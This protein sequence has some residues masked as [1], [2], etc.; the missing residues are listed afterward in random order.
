[1]NIGVDFAPIWQGAEDFLEGRSPYAEHTVHGGYIHPPGSTVLISPLSLLPYDVAARLYTMLCACSI[2]A[3]GFLVFR[4][5]PEASWRRIAIAALIV[6]IA[7]PV[8]VALG[9]GNLEPMALLA[10]AA[11]LWALAQNRAVLAGV[12]LGLGLAIKPTLAPL[13]LLPFVVGQV[14]AGGIA[15]ATALAINLFGFLVVPDSDRFFTSAVPFIY[16]VQPTVDLNAALAGIADRYDLGGTAITAFQIIGLVALAGVVI[17]YWRDL[18]NSRY[19]VFAFTALFVLAGLLVPRYSFVP[20]G[21][22]LVL[23]LPLLV[24][25]QTRL[26]I[27]LAAAA[28]YMIAFPELPDRDSA[29]FV[30]LTDSRFMVGYAL[31][32]CVTILVARRT[33]GPQPS[34]Q[35]I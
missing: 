5:A 15:L 32:A 3:A 35:P 29:W 2:L 30:R 12:T 4:A 23:A 16:D 6:A 9:L 25:V 14:Q 18:Q 13:L 34:E 33:G 19:R 8:Q 28:G 27:V 26:E 1:V 21:I 31:L 11:S 10:F 7:R 20:Y 24:M 17:A 22:Y